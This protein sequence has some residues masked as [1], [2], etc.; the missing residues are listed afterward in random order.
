MSQISETLK[1]IGNKAGAFFDETQDS[2]YIF[3]S[4][5]IVIAIVLLVSSWFLTSITQDKRD[6]DN[7]NKSLDKLSE[8]TTGKHLYSNSRTIED[9]NKFR[10]VYK[11]ALKHYYI[12]TAYNCCC[13]YGY[14]NVFVNECALINALKQGARCL[15]FEI[16]SINLQPVVAVSSVKNYTIKESYNVI[17]L[18]TILNVLRQ[19]RIKDLSKDYDIETTDPIFLHF[20]IKSAIPSI[21]DKIFDILNDTLD[22]RSSIKEFLIDQ[23]EPTYNYFIGETSEIQS[24]PNISLSLKDKNSVHKLYNKFIIMIHTAASEK[25]KLKNSNLGSLTNIY[26]G[27]NSSSCELHTYSEINNR[28]ADDILTKDSTKQKLYI[29]LPDQESNVD[30]G[31]WQ[32]ILQ[33]LGCQFIGMKFQTSDF[34]LIS[35]LDFFKSKGNGFSF[36]HKPTELRLDLNPIPMQSRPTNILPDKPWPNKSDGGKIIITNEAN[37]V[38]SVIIKTLRASMAPGNINS[39]KMADTTGN[40]VTIENGI[41]KEFFVKNIES[42]TQFQ[43]TTNTD[44]NIDIINMENCVINFPTFTILPRDQAWGVS[45]ITIKLKVVN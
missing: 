21:Y 34:N 35:Y 10:D 7:Y 14:K 38:E 19:T 26:T 25:I 3:I 12:K 27:T 4:F 28:G 40:G 30:N 24:W 2:E 37:S 20:R 22:T 1:E 15:D 31:N 18:K 41:T 43:F 29:V 5:I 8:Y 33:V 17:P 9:K 42:A 6:C 16:Y 39:F 44:Q 23:T 45:Q 32:E 36:A 13:A 11:N